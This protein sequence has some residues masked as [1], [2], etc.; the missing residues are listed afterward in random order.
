ML[1]IDLDQIEAFIRANA[2]GPL[3]D[4]LEDAG[5]PQDDARVIAEMVREERAKPE[6]E[7]LAIVHACKAL[8]RLG[9]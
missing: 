3:R 4:Y 5:V 1:P 7:S 9:R 8:K 6:N 2:F